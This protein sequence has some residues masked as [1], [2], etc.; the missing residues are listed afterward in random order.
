MVSPA[1]L[2][3]ARAFLGWNMERAAEDAGIHRRTMVR[4]ENDASYVE[5]QPASLKRLV[6]AYRERRILLEGKGLSISGHC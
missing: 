1:Q 5:R 6:E 4:L 3:A 2:R